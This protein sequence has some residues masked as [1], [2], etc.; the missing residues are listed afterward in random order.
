MA[1]IKFGYR[2]LPS[3]EEINVRFLEHVKLPSGRMS[4]SAAL[5]ALAECLDSP[6]HLKP[7]IAGL[8]LLIS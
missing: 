7:L 5:C 8:F 2:L 6:L 3:Y 4:G 1:S